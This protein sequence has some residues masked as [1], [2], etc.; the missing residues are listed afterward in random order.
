[1][2]DDS[3]SQ[4]AAA[5]NVLFP[6]Y[7]SSIQSDTVFRKVQVSEPHGSSDSIQLDTG[8]FK[9]I[10]ETKARTPAPEPEN[11]RDAFTGTLGLSI[12]P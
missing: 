9:L 3:P 7:A 2:D 1:M 11:N 5:N 12:G 10:L 6:L 4:S 8:R